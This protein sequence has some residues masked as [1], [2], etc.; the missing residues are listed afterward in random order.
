MKP[1]VLVVAGDA[2][3]A[4]A[5]APVAKLLKADNRVDVRSA[6]Y[7][8][9]AEVWERNG[10]GCEKLSEQ[11]DDKALFELGAD[12]D[13][14]LLGT[15][16]NG[17]NY[18][19]RLGALFSDRSVAVLDFWSNVAP[20]FRA[21]NGQLALP[22]R[23]CVMDE[24]VRDL[25]IE[26]GF[27]SVCLTVT[28]QP[29]FDRLAEVKSAL[30]PEERE[31]IRNKYAANGGAY[32]VLFASQPLAEF[33]ARPELRD[34]HPG[35]DQSTVL[36]KLLI[37]LDRLIDQR[38]LSISLLVRPHPRENPKT[39]AWVS[40]HIGPTRVFVS[41]DE[42]GI[43]GALSADLVCGMNTVM[44]AEACF[45]GCRVIS[46]Q[47]GLTGRDMLPTNDLGLSQLV[48]TGAEL[49]HALEVN[50]LTPA[51]LNNVLFQSAIKYIDGRAGRRVADEVYRLLSVRKAQ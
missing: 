3:G 43:K 25:M 24:A 13:V 6:V 1:R 31:F 51:S 11:L 20:R 38:S 30:L 28:G 19:R 46:I 40:E 29:A 45:V 2:G 9:A 17:V 47:P 10:L 39:L 41:S 36:R 14:L 49:N 18:E 27:D 22:H 4:A 5:V 42:D 12:A 16:V 33:Y 44:L 23:I 48:R 8:Q 35:Y 37:G 26:E 50:L 7:R 15:S 32:L 21:E 34:H